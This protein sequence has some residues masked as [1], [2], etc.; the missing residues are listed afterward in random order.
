M[1]AENRRTLL[2]ASLL[3][4]VAIV[5]KFVAGYAQFWFKGNKKVIGVGMIPRSEVGLI[6]AQ[7]GLATEVFD[8]RIFG[9]VQSWSW[10][11]P[12]SLLLGSRCS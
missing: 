11:L 3:I 4:A 2:V 6:F 8:E 1:V 5:G 12:L 7:R 9:A 10:L